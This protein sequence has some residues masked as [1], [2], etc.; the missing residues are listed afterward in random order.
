[1]LKRILTI[2]ILFVLFFGNTMFSQSLRSRDI[3]PNLASEEVKPGY[4][5]TE[6]IW[7]IQVNY[8]ATTV[9][10]L[11]GNAAAIYL[12]SVGEFWTSR[13]ASALYI[14]GPLQVR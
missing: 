4:P 3:S 5:T 8:D 12:P 2:S 14:D 13:W 10:G 9:T 11:A 6:A 7:D 1:M